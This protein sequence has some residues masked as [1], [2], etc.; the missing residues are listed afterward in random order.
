MCEVN[1]QFEVDE[2]GKLA[3]VILTT[4]EEFHPAY[5]EWI[6]LS[7]RQASILAERIAMRIESPSDF[8]KEDR[9]EEISLGV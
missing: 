8:R 6:E 7:P 5:G 9:P 4:P 3:K 1:V 2:E